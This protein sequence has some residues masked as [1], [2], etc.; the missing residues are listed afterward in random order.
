MLTI[1]ILLTNNKSESE[2]NRLVWYSDI[3]HVSNCQMSFIQW[4]IWITGGMSVIQMVIPI[5]E[6]VC[7]INVRNHSNNGQLFECQL[8]ISWQSVLDLVITCLVCFES[9][10][11]SF[12]YTL[13]W[14]TIY[15]HFATC[16]NQYT[17]RLQCW[18]KP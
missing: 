5:F 4:V 2:K 15:V 12:M 8:F 17:Q 7:N 16:Y 18:E 10:S 14:S 9:N 6:K 3:R 11:F 13:A 1:T